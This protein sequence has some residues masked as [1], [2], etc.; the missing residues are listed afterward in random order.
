ME[1]KEIR[2]I[3]LLLLESEHKTLENLA[4][5][6]DSN[7]GHLSQIKN[8]SRDMGKIVARRIEEKLEKEAG[9][10]DLLHTE[11][12]TVTDPLENNLLALY[13]MLRT[14]EARDTLLGSAQRL[15]T[16]ENPGKSLA[17]PYGH[18]TDTVK[19]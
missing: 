15:V 14:D 1:N 3:N 16:K 5:L 18:A 13:R 19:R 7:A 9:W 8:G 4:A 6:T 2:R 12:Q 17:N 10:M 11:V